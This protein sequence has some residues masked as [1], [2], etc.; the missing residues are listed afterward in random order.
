MYGLG[1]N[2]LES[3]NGTI[4]AKAT[5]RSDFN[6]THWSRAQI[7]MMNRTHD[8]GPVGVANLVRSHMGLP[9]LTNRAAEKMEARDRRGKKVVVGQ[10]HRTEE[11]R[12]KASTDRYKNKDRVTT[13]TAA[14]KANHDKRAKENKILP[15]GY[16]THGVA[17]L[18]KKLAAEGEDVEG[19]AD[20]ESGRTSGKQKGK[21]KRKEAGGTAIPEYNAGGS[22]TDN[23]DKLAADVRMGG[24]KTGGV[25]SSCLEAGVGRQFLVDAQHA[26]KGA[27]IC[28][29]TREQW[30]A[31][32]AST[33][34][35]S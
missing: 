8:D 3:M 11:Q 27:K 1:T 9:P 2:F 5:K 17:A 4:A 24:T 29:R 22:N 6:R 31:R 28:S 30:G 33:K 21:R 34:D 16:G 7:A 12:T 23:N 14:N 25:C 20:G 19:T 26:R 32:A 10:L 35:K 13:Q 15:Y 18:R